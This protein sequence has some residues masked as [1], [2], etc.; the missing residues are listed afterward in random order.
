VS[1]SERDRADG[2]RDP[3]TDPP[4][5]FQTIEVKI[6]SGAIRQV[7]YVG[8]TLHHVAGSGSGGYVIVT[9]WRPIEGGNAWPHTRED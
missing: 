3:D 8:R 1:I 9:A 4:P 7:R 2:W 6:K 5:D